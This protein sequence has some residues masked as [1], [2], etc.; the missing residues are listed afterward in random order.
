MSYKNEDIPLYLLPFSSA[1]TF[2]KSYSC[3][4]SCSTKAVIQIKKEKKE[5]NFQAHI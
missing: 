5:W 2:H 3:I 1:Y 4:W